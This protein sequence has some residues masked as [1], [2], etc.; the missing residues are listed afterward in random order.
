M[1]ANALLGSIVVYTMRWEF[2]TSLLRAITFRFLTRCSLMLPQQWIKTG[3]VSPGKS[4]LAYWTDDFTHARTLIPYWGCEPCQ[5][6]LQ[7]VT[8]WLNIN[9]GTGK[10]EDMLQLFSLSMLNMSVVI[11]IN[12]LL[13]MFVFASSVILNM[14]QQLQGNIRSAEWMVQV[15]FPNRAMA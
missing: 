2:I 9:S 14:I 12:V 3:C 1:T 11:R 4:W 10:T 15:L 7:I 6:S 5:K 13:W 8:M